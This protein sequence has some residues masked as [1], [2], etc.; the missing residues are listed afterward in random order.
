MTISPAD[1]LPENVFDRKA[2]PPTSHQANSLGKVL[3]F[4]PDLGW[5]EG[6]WQYPSFTNSTH[7][8]YA[9]ER[10]PIQEDPKLVRDRT[11]QK[12]LSSMPAEMP[13]AAEAL[14]KLGWNAAWDRK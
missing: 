3:W 4:A 7:W 8:T 12:W 11:F 14:T 5:A 2:N 1:A 9:P 6:D 10:P 13:A